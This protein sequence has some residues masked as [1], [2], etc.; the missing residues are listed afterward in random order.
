MSLTNVVVGKN[1]LQLIRIPIEK[2]K[3]LRKSK[4]L[5]SYSIVV[6]LFLIYIM[7]VSDVYHGYRSETESY[8]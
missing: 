1:G 3:V 6:L 5:F 8:L 2:N 7:D 4:I